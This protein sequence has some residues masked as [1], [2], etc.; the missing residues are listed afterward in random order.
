[1]VQCLR[2]GREFG[3]RKQALLEVLRQS[4]HYGSLRQK[5]KAKAE[6]KAVQAQRAADDSAGSSNVSCRISVVCG[7][8]RNEYNV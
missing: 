8:G 1:M 3:Q 7:R 5:H 6:A 2:Q 4:E